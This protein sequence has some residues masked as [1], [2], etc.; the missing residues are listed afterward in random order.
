MLC[1]FV[2]GT[3]MTTTSCSSDNG[4][5]A[6]ILGTLLTNLL[7]Q[8]GTVY[9]FTGNGTMQ[10]LKNTAAAGTD[11]VWTKVTE[12]LTFQ[13]TLPLT[14][15]NTAATL[16]IPAL[17]LGGNQMSQVTFSQLVLTAHS[18]GQTVDYTKID[19]GTSSTATGTLTVNGTAYNVS[20]LYIDAKAT[21]ET[22]TVKGMSI[23]FGD[24]FEYV[25]NVVFT[26]TAAAQ[27]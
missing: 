27:Q 18:S 22:M 7:G 5:I 26:G 6:Q 17:N 10:V 23:Y 8:Q 12:S 15:N 9:N 19:T 21:N 16:Q 20:N 1:L 3:A 25:V 13:G 24:N 2:A 14:V 4:G 11:P